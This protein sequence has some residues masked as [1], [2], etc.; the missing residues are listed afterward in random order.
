MMLQELSIQR[1]VHVVFWTLILAQLVLVTCHVGAIVWDAAAPSNVTEIVRSFFELSKEGNAPTWFSSFLFTLIGLAC[2]A[3]YF[4]EKQTLSDVAT[5][6]RLRPAWLVF[7]AAFLFLSFDETSQLHERLDWLMSG[8]SEGG[9]ASTPVE[10]QDADELPFYRYLL[11][12]VP[13]LAA[14]GLA[15]AWFVIS[16]FRDTTTSL[17]FLL[18]MGLLGMKLV[19]ESFEKWSLSM[20]W[21]NHSVYLETVIVEMCCLFTGAT[22]IVTS[23]LRHL[24]K[25]CHG[26]DEHGARSASIAP[27]PIRG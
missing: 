14:L 25:L 12:Y 8:F 6:E 11:I 26:E 23:L 3:I 13:V 2:G 22:I 19:I 21:F 9:Q 10:A 15:M 17:L 5:V 24:A 27:S 7:A 1:S 16:R 18:G 20:T 4:V